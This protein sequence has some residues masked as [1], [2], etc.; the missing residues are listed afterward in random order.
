MLGVSL[1]QQGE[2]VAVQHL[3]QQ[4]FVIVA[5]NY[6]CPIGE[7]D[8]IAS[9]GRTLHF[10][11]VKTR[12]SVRFGRPAEAVNPA[13]QHKLRQLALYYTAKVHHEGPVDFGVVEVLYD[14][15]TANPEVNFILGAF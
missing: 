3:L 8:L 10:I 2:A 9:Q 13:K 6:R 11:E 1:G 12:S 7:I 4:K 15:D 14:D 5:K